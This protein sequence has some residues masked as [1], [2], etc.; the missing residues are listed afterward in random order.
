M[1]EIRA[2]TFDVFGTVVD[3]R[4]GVL[5]EVRSVGAKLGVD[6]DWEAFVD[7]WRYDGYIGGIARVQRGELPFMTADA[8][9]R[10]KLDELIASYG[11]GALTE[12]ERDDLNRAWHRLDPWPDA[13][14]GLDRLRSKFM[15]ST[16]SNGNLSLLVNMS[17]R[18]G[19]RWDCVLSADL[20][21]AFK[22]QAE[23]Y[24]G[25]VRHLD[26]EPNQVL[27]VAAHKNDL[28]AAQKAG[29][30]TAFVPRPEEAGPQRNIDLTPDESF[31]FVAEDF[32]ALAS[33]L[34]CD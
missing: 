32:E 11:L 31:D 29:L 23:C 4:G 10:R 27:M 30:R 1:T 17:R 15:V 20:L 28:F 12:A 24:L 8:L 18:A 13:V 2:L 6:A 9:H 16:L 22:P 21:G 19:L 5:R 33:Q 3:W 7:D 34:G 26:L 25:A 14:A